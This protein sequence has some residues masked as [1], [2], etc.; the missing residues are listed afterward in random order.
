MEFQ[1]KIFHI[2]LAFSYL[3]PQTKK[4]TRKTT[5][6]SLFPQNHP[7]PNLHHPTNPSL[8]NQNNLYSQ[9]TYQNKRP[10][11]TWQ[12][13]QQILIQKHTQTLN[14]P[15]TVYFLAY[16]SQK[17]RQKVEKKNHAQ[18]HTLFNNSLKLD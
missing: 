6:P 16:N 3:S 2:K 10:N 17:D 15:K 1:Y 12:F 9:Q 8:T 14:I 7:I 18:S 13:S 11:Q 4:K 5:F